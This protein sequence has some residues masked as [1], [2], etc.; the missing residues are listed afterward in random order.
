M[1][2]GPE[3]IENLISHNQPQ[4][5]DIKGYQKTV[6]LMDD[7]KQWLQSKGIDISNFNQLVK[8]DLDEQK[9]AVCADDSKGKL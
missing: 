5:E 3:P 7:L 8:E 1:S 6:D 2:E 4:F 9:G